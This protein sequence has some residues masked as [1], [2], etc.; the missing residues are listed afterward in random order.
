MMMRRF[1]ML[2]GLLLIINKGYTQLPYDSITKEFVD[3]TI[4]YLASDK[5]KGRVNYTSEQL[6]AAEYLGKQFASFGLSPFPGMSNFYIPFRN[7]FNIKAEE[8]LE[9]NGRKMADSLFFFLPSGLST[10]S[11]KLDDF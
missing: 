6:E 1:N 11:S 4:N 3:K 8:K 2:M 9:W 7:T 10:E 5:L